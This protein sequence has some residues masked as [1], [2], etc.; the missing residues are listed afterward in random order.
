MNMPETEDTTSPHAS[1]GSLDEEVPRSD[2]QARLLDEHARL[3]AEL[4]GVTFDE[5]LEPVREHMAR[6]DTERGELLRVLAQ[7]STQLASIQTE[8]QH[9]RLEYAQLQEK[10]ARI[11]NALDNVVKHVERLD[12]RVSKLEKTSV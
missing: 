1:E 8:V 4:V 3:F 10:W 5:K 6:E 12:D 2:P 7:L 11:A 9:S